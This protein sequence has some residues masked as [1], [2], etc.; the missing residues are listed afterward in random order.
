MQGAQD[1]AKVVLDLYDAALRA[2]SRN[3]YCTGQR[4]YDRFMTRLKTGRYFPF[5]PQALSE[6]E[7][8]LAFYMAFLLMEPRIKAADTILKY[9]SPVKFKFREEGCPEELYTTP[10]KFV[11]L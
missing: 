11:E 9:E 6:T 3:V 10:F 7:L 8:Y 2:S 5:Q 1:L 4:A